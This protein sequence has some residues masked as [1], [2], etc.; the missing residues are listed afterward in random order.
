MLFDGIFRH[1]LLFNAMALN[2]V[3]LGLA[4]GFFLYTFHS[5]RHRGLLLQQGE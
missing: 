1:D 4:T 5:A 2:V 3:Y